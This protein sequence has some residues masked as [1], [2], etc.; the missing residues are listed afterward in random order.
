MAVVE[1]A[2]IITTLAKGT[3]TGEAEEEVE[4]Q[5]A[6]RTLPP[7]VGVAVTAEVVGVVEEQGATEDHNRATGKLS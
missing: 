1:V 2:P 6:T 7:V 4:V 5:V 3:A